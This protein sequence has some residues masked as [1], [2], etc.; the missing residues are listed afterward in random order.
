MGNQLA[1]INVLDANGIPTGEVKTKQEIHEQGLWHNAAHIWIYNSRGEILMQLRAKDKDSYPG[2]W[3]ISVSG[4]TDSGETPIQSAVRE[5]KEEIGLNP[6]FGKLEPDG[7]Y[8]ISQPIEGTLWQ[9]NEIGHVFFYKF[10]GNVEDLSM[11]DG[12]VEKLEFVPLDL[13]QKEVN[14]PV[15]RIKYVP[16]QPLGEYYN[17]IA[18]KVKEKLNEASHKTN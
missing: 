6:E 11:P 15:T 8:I 1:L 9:D 7:T 5:M 2:L 18:D 13:F 16:Y 17:W 4:H 10:I 3:D 14:D 12:E